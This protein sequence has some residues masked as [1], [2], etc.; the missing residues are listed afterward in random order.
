MQDAV[1][2]AILEAA[3]NLSEDKRAT[4]RSIAKA[5][6]EVT[7][8]GP[9][10]VCTYDVATALPD[11]STSVFERAD[12]HYA[13]SFAER[14]RAIPIELRRSLLSLD[15]TVLDSQ[16]E[17]VDKLPVQLRSVLH[18]LP[19]VVI[20]ATTGSGDC[21]SIG[22]DDPTVRD[23]PPSRI[24]HLHALSQHL[25]VAWRIRTT[26]NVGE[27][28]PVSA[29]KSRVDGT[30]TNQSPDVLAPTA[31][32]VLR[33]AV[34]A[35]ER[36]RTGQQS[37]SHRGLWPALV[38]GRW[39][40]LDAFIATGTRYVVA[41]KNPAATTALRALSPRERSVLEHVLAGRSGK[42]IALELELSE[43]AVTR[44][45]RTA[46]RR[47]GAADT[48]A[49]VGLPTALFEPLD[50]LNTSVDLM[51][52]RLTP[53]SFCLTSLSEA[54]RAIVTGILDGK[55]VLVIARERGTSPRTVGHQIDNIYK[56]LG[57]SS[58]RELLARLA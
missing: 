42:W 4:L 6:T 28:T 25:A 36:A 31:R 17:R 19:L 9:V 21:L 49:L 7:P 46:L 11:L 10:S 40:L 54:E 1:T 38:D 24:Q 56:K 18:G 53:E 33:R 13:I 55:R 45:L 15:P 51:I 58:R 50:G 3:Y 37:A 57:V 27:I 2:L 32:E 20:M 22:F 26:L 14:I 29:A 41:Y 23:W 16:S 44:T 34:I 47:I 39:S 52:T 8:R 48:A 30:P 35:R 43:S 5:A 12:D